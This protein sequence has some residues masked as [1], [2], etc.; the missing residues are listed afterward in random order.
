MGPADS[1]T[2]LE[3]GRDPGPSPQ[4]LDALARTLH[5]GFQRF[6][7]LARMIFPGPAGRDFHRDGDRAADSCVAEPRAAYGQDPDSP[8]IT[9]VVDRSF[10]I[11]GDRVDCLDDL[12]LRAYGEFKGDE[13]HHAGYLMKRG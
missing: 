5:S 6:A 7:N 12:G 4:V 13:L 11:D 3:Q 10:R 9:E 8:R 1:C 2:R